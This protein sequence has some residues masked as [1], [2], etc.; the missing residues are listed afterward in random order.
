MTP[1]PTATESNTSHNY[2]GVLALGA[3]RVFK[4]LSK[5][6]NHRM[7]PDPTAKENSHPGSPTKGKTMGIG[8]DPT[9]YREP[10]QKRE[11]TQKLLLTLPDSEEG[12]ERCLVMAGDKRATAAP[13]L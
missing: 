13:P 11:G 3:S 2:E 1:T 5:G 10:L 6:R 12:P 8:P 4:L 7:E 9:N